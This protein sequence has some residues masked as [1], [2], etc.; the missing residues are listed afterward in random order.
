MKE[1]IRR[2]LCL[3]M[4][5]VWLVFDTVLQR[6]QK[7]TADLQS[8]AQLVGV[9]GMHGG[10]C[11]WDTG[12]GSGH[13]YV[14]NSARFRRYIHDTVISSIETYDASI[15]MGGVSSTKSEVLDN[16]QLNQWRSIY[17]K[18]M[19]LGFDP[20]RCQRKPQNTLNPNKKMIKKFESQTKRGT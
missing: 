14:G 16:S 19:R 3:L 6:Q 11:P 8:W 10:A 7:W 17:L 15:K 18:Y 1:E 9:N 2:N 5:S 13:L 4:M 12:R 20:W